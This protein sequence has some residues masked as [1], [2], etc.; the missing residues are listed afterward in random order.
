MFWF[1][2]CFVNYLFIFLEKERFLLGFI[3]SCHKRSPCILYVIRLS[4][5]SLKW[6]NTMIFQYFISGEFLC[7]Y[8]HYIHSLRLL[9][10]Q[11]V[12]FTFSVDCNQF[13]CFLLIRFC[14][15][16]F[17]LHDMFCYKW[18]MLSMLLGPCNRF[19]C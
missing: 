19:A 8:L 15:F 6:Y 18:F 13:T 7:I 2:S 4:L 9:I 11:V 16:I 12:F 10:V 3:S 1:L 5:C 14:L 17:W